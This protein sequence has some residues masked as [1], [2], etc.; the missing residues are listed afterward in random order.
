[1][2]GWGEIKGISSNMCENKSTPWVEWVSSTI[3]EIFNARAT[4]LDNVHENKGS[5]LTLSKSEVTFAPWYL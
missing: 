3:T 5:K 2:A 4:T 1:M